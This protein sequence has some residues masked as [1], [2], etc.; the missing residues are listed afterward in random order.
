MSG[1]R[2]CVVGY[3]SATIQGGY[4]YGERFDN[5]EPCC[6]SFEETFRYTGNH[7][8]SDFN[9]ESDAYNSKPGINLIVRGELKVILSPSQASGLSTAE[10]EMRFC[11]F[12]GA[13]IVLKKTRSVR[14]VMQEKTVP[15]GFKEEECD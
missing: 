9:C 11:P 12:C 2:Q 15:A 5:L 1:E 4:G 14:L 10:A 3:K 6:E 7:K 13:E 8:V